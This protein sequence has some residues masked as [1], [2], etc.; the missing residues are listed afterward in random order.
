MY[1]EKK[2]KTLSK[3]QFR[4]STSTDFMTIFFI[5]KPEEHPYFTP[6]VT[7]VLGVVLGEINRYNTDSCT[8]TN[9][10]ITWYH[11]QI[12]WR[13]EEHTVKYWFKIDLYVL[14]SQSC[15]SPFPLHKSTIN[16]TLPNKWNLSM[17]QA[18][19]MSFIIVLALN[20]N[21]HMLPATNIP[22]KVG[23]LSCVVFPP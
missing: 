21:M 9:A 17:I 1:S 5:S 10:G 6:D 15:R 19:L 2:L 18:Q 11:G 4:S 7:Y 3:K 14:I 20:C 16:V 12:P 8:N 13:S 23:C 22:I